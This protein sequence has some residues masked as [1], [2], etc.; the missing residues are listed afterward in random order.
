MDV[1]GVDVLTLHFISVRVLQ[2][3]WGLGGIGWGGS[4]RRGHG[5]GGRRPVAIR[6]LWRICPLRISVSNS[7]S[8][9][10]AWCTCMHG[11]LVCERLATALGPT[12]QLCWASFPLNVCLSRWPA[13]TR[14]LGCVLRGIG[15]VVDVVGVGVVGV[16]VCVRVCVCVCVCVCLCVCVCVAQEWY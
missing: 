1:A 14:E 13:R 6:A 7:S 16:V 12:L 11:L 5:G 8:C 10:C 3:K 9:Q 2:G 4:G 15:V